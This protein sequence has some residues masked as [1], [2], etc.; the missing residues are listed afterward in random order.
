MDDLAIVL[1]KVLGIPDH[2]VIKARTHRQQHIAILHGVVGF[3]GA[4]HA[5][6]AQELAVRSRVSSQAHQR[7]GDGVTQHVH[8]RAQLVR[9][10]AQQHAATGVDVGTLGGQQ[11]LERLANLAAVALAHGVVRA[12]FY[13]LWIS[14][15]RHLLERD[16]LGDVHH[17]R[18]WPTGTGNVEC[19]LERHGQITWIFDQEIVFD[20]G[21]RDADRIAFLESIQT[22]GCRG[23]LTRDDHHRDAVHV[24]GSDAG[25][26]I[27]EARAGCHQCHTHFTGGAGIPVCSVHCG[28]FVAHQHMLNGVL[29]VESVVDIENSS[30]WVPPDEL[31][32]LCLKRLDENLGTH[33]ILRSVRGC[34]CSGC[35]CEFCFGNF[36]DKPL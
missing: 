31:N 10:V 26:G 21:A 16:I 8:Q 1:R 32:V 34:L 22:N 18:P 29:L 4:V 12:H 35:H 7:V 11:Q 2:A 36:H 14:R 20:D 6:H 17:H 24:G 27:R 33:Q 30:A 9:R 3:N 23:H 5:Q 28:L 25:H 15:V 13:A 19:L